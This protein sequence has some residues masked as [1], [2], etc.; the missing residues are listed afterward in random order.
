ME[1]G[2]HKCAML[3][4]ERGSVHRT[5]GVKLSDEQT[6]KGLNEGDTYKYLQSV[7]KLLSH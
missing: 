4:V 2:I 5:E 7:A 1:F 3:V 6:I